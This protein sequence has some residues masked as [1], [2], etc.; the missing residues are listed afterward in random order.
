METVVTGAGDPVEG[1][2]ALSKLPMIRRLLVPLDG[3]PTAELV[4]PYARALARTFQAEIRLL[5]VLDA[6]VAEEA[7]PGHA[8]S[9]LDS[10]EWR[11]AGREA[12]AYLR[13]IAADLTKGGLR[14]GIEVGFGKPEENILQAIR[15]QAVELVALTVRGRC[16]GTAATVVTSSGISVMIVRATAPPA[17]PG[18]IERRFRL[19]L[20][21]VDV[22]MRAEW[23][24]CLAAS[25][26]QA[27]DAEL[28]IAHVIAPPAMPPPLFAVPGDADLCAAIVRRN[29]T[30]AEQYLH[31]MVERLRAP[32]LN[33]RSAI[34]EAES[35]A[36]ALNDLGEQERAD[37]L[38]LS[39]HGSSGK[40]LWPYGSVTGALLSFAKIPLLIFQDLPREAAA[41]A[42]A[43]EPAPS[44]PETR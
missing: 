19:V 32:G 41:V 28:L 18:E 14:S 6:E 25:L 4:L 1:G 27:H 39:A 42:V 36:Q 44:R 29:R 26:A 10:A 31:E 2:S 35:V 23:A 5:R 12:E 20:V 3:T 37:L 21:A 16:G 43:V 22:S 17:P 40:S 34:L 11:L 8:G 24:L 33:V 30:A 15:T 13:S 38:V 7:G 9:A